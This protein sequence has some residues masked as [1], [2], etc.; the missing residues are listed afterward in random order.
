MSK[1]YQDLAAHGGRSPAEAGMLRRFLAKCGF[2]LNYMAAGLFLA[3]IAVLAVA[4]FQAV[5]AG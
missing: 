5:T 4:Y 3:G 2:E 1:A